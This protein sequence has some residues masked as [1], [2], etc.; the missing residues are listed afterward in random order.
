MRMR[1]CNLWE[2]RRL[3]APAAEG[4][5]ER[6]HGQDRT[7]LD[8][9][10]GPHHL[11]MHS[12]CCCSPVAAVT[13]VFFG[14]SNGR[15][16]P[17]SFAPACSAPA[18]G[19]SIDCLL[20]TLWKRVF[21]SSSESPHCLHFFTLSCTLF[22]ACLF[23][24]CRAVSVCQPACQLRVKSSP[25]RRAAGGRLGV[26]VVDSGALPL[27][28]HAATRVAFCATAATTKARSSQI[29]SFVH[30]Y[31]H[32]CIYTCVCVHASIYRQALAA[33]A[34]AIIFQYSNVL[35][36]QNGAADAFER[37][38]WDGWGRCC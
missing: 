31:M 10:S 13:E 32:W 20:I 2:W 24:R 27:W 15:W 9:C 8:R 36:P 11:G 17:P 29:H 23:L 16:A 18:D 30:S 19:S 35:V 6:S 21:Y 22:A 3:R 26:V 33:Q 7:G 37:S 1:R 28:H 25:Q 34:Q 12:S 38:T 14:M 4:E 5:P